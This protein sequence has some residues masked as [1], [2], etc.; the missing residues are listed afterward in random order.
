MV[1]LY[2]VCVFGDLGSV[3]PGGEE[4]GRH[5]G[6]RIVR[7][8]LIAGKRAR[9]AAA[10]VSALGY[11][12]CGAALLPA[13]SWERCYELVFGIELARAECEYMSGATEAA[14]GRLSM[15]S[16]RAR[17]RIDLA[18]VVCVQ[19]NLFGMTER[20]QRTVDTCLEHMRQVGIEWSLGA[21]DDEVRRVCEAILSERTRTGNGA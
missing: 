18:S 5:Q 3:R 6:R 1:S 21:T 2:W 9:S 19:T 17:D 7:L 20:Y 16:R 8:N 13:D 15:L 14:E 12:N 4:T 11:F 10:Y